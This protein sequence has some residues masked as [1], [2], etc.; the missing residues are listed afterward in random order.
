[1][2]GDRGVRWQCPDRDCNWS[3]VGTAVAQHDAGPRCVC[4]RTMR[5]GDSVPAF[6]YLDFLREDPAEEEALEVE[7]E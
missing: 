4:G 5:R 2:P 1:M 7:K 6:Q 3:F